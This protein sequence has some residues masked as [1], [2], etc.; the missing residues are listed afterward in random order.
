MK[1]YTTITALLLVCSAW[2]A[3]MYYDG[4]YFNIISDNELSLVHHGDVVEEYDDLAYFLTVEN[5]YT[6]LNPRIVIPDR[7]NYNGVTYTV[8]TID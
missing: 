1:L 5:N 8:T 6:N 2:A 7:L 4:L 3:D